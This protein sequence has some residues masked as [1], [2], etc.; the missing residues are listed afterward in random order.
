MAKYRYAGG[1]PHDDGQGGLVRPG[2]EWDWPGEPEWGPWERLDGGSGSDSPAPAAQEDA[3]APDSAAAASETPDAA[4]S[5]PGGSA[6][7][8]A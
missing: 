4:T 6:G 2:D 1:G 7:K 3:E 8:E 5:A